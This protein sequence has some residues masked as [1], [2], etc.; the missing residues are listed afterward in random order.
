MRSPI[1]VLRRYSAVVLA[2]AF[3]ALAVS[4]AFM[5]VVDRF[6]AQIQVHPVHNAFGVAMI[7]AGLLH[8]VLHWKSLVAHLRHRGA[9]AFAIIVAGVMVLR[10]V[11]GFRRPT[12]AESEAIRK[13]EEIISSAGRARHGRGGGS[14][15]S[16]KRGL[17]G[18]AAPLRQA[19]SRAASRRAPARRSVASTKAG[20]ALR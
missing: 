11:A 20:R 7:G 2:V 16:C 8:A 18:S 5:L 12:E 19:M 9:R 3:V 1:A 13:I 4:G 6:G 14:L 17:S 15:R 10:F